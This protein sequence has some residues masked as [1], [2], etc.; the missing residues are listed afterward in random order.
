MKKVALLVVGLLCV[1]VA[2]LAGEVIT[3]DTGE[4]ATLLRVVFSTPV[5]I[6]AFGD[7]L[8]NVDQEGL[9]YEFV[10]SGG[11]VPPWG[12]H[13]MNWSPATAQITKYEWLIGFV[14]ASG[15]AKGPASTAEAI[16]SDH[17]SF[18]QWTRSDLCGVDP[19]DISTATWDSA[20][21]NDIV[22][23]Y[24][25]RLASCIQIR[26]DLLDL[27]ENVWDRVDLKIELQRR[28][29]RGSVVIT[30]E[31]PD[32]VVVSV[33]GEQAEAAVFDIVSDTFIDAISL[34]ID[35]EV[36]RNLGFE[37]AGEITVTVEAVRSD[38]RGKRDVAGPYRS[39]AVV[40]PLPFVYQIAAWGPGGPGATWTD[41]LAGDGSGNGYLRLLES[42]KRWEQPLVLVMDEEL[43]ITADEYG[44]LPY[45]QELQEQGL[46]EFSGSAP[47]G[48]GLSWQ[49]AEVGAKSLSWMSKFY[50]ELGLSSGPSF[51]PYE[52]IISR[53]SF[54]VISAGGFPLITSCVS[55]CYN[56]FGR[57]PYEG[58]GNV[59]RLHKV[60]DQLVAFFQGCVDCNQ[61]GSR[62]LEDVLPPGHKK[63]LISL[64]T[65]IVEEPEAFV[66]WSD[67]GFGF[68]GLWPEMYGG[69]P[70]Y[71]DAFLQWV[72]AHPW[73]DM[74][75]FE[76]LLGRGISAVDEAEV[77]PIRDFHPLEG[78]QHYLAYYPLHY[79]GGTAD[80]HSPNVSAGEHIEGYAE[81]LPIIADG[82]SIPS[83]MRMGDA[84][85]PGTIVYEVVNSLL[86]APAND[87]TE[88]AWYAYFVCSCAQHERVTPDGLIGGSLLPDRVK[89]GATWLRHIGA[90]LEASHWAVLAR[91][92][93]VSSVTSVNLIDLDWDDEDEVVMSNDRVF[94][95]FENDG[96]RLELLVSYYPD[97]GKAIPLVYP[98]WL[99]HGNRQAGEPSTNGESALFGFRI[100]APDA[101]F[102]ER[103]MHDLPYVIETGEDF[104]RF[105]SPDE[106]V[107]KSFTLR[108]GDVSINIDYITDGLT[109]V[110]I[111]LCVNPLTLFASGTSTHWQHLETQQDSY[112]ECA[113]GGSAHLY[114]QGLANK[115]TFSFL[116]PTGW[117]RPY[118]T[119]EGKGIG[120][121]SFTLDTTSTL[122]RETG[123]D[124]PGSEASTASS[125]F[126]NPYEV[127]STEPLDCQ[128]LIDNF[129][130][131][132]EQTFMGWS[133]DFDSEELH[134]PGVDSTSSCDITRETDDSG[135]RYLLATYKHASWMK[136]R[137]WGFP[138]VNVREYDGIEVILWADREQHVS[139]DLGAMPSDLGWK[140]GHIDGIRITE[141]PTTFRFP[142]A[143]FRSPSAPTAG[144]FLEYIADLIA[145]AVY[146]ERGA[147]A[148]SMDDIYFY[149]ASH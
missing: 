31:S 93:E 27:P 17:K 72:A 62:R 95:I 130:D 56:W 126:S 118:V 123:S 22:A 44:H 99:L 103:G 36:L 25:R 23:V 146:F 86:A 37:T 58:T 67:D 79:Y 45:L 34:C 84:R 75:T 114:S 12:S 24:F 73:V 119:I 26:A 97:L 129:E 104:V 53:E 81:Y 55:Q 33:S 116:P 18:L 137:Y 10:F 64:T 82:Q 135:N 92:G 142:F 140:D 51:A 1:S 63:N 52:A 54:D 132:L 122:D 98:A 115:S 87:L 11:T 110:S 59:F 19:A 143:E 128:L 65:R 111:G 113:L 105:T 69:G 28:V 101:A 145:I 131:S 16:V 106:S 85:T 39:S 43:L 144:D 77:F 121:F 4:D 134:T 107:T 7:V 89:V 124:V 2:A 149:K 94:A 100:P 102:V 60:N 6:T 42:V 88:L 112:V 21:P 40:S 32:C 108:N 91:T 49:E 96:G 14:D 148:V 74:M 109:T 83:G 139:I 48:F 70:E 35:T 138:S 61:L 29:R 66:F 147:G 5:L 120:A 30:V 57:S 13:W 8:I 47:V 46:L 3:N 136:L 50:S 20:E 117:Y 133:I 41:I 141:V 76:E 127:L 90:I 9:S 78:D 71:F 80:G 125:R 68:S 38:G 15:F